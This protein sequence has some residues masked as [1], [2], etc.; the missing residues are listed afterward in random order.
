MADYSPD[1]EKEVV[2]SISRAAAL[3]LFDYLQLCDDARRRG[4]VRPPVGLEE[5]VALDE[6][7]CELESA[8][9]EPFATNYAELLAEAKRRLTQC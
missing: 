2:I 1:F 8:L 6:V 3:V 9:A 5:V 7:N 4:E